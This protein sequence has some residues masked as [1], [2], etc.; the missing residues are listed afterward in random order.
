M[1][2]DIIIPVYNNR[3]YLVDALSSCIVQKYKN[4][5]IY[6]IDDNSDEPIEDV[7]K[8]F[9]SMN[10]EYIRNSKN[11]GPSASR[12]IGIKKGSGDLVSFLDSDD[13]WTPDKLLLSISEFKKDSNIGMTC[14]NYRIW[15]ERSR[16]NKQ[17]YRHPIVVDFNSLRRVNYVASGSVTVKRKVLD[18]VG[19][20]NEEYRVAEDYDLWIRIS[21][22]YKIKYIHDVLYY[23][24]CVSDGKSLTKRSDLISHSDD[25]HKKIKAKYYGNSS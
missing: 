15:N 24:S 16:L 7:I 1:K 18:D 13:I 22:K 25:V 21:K 12:N 23:Y 10:I 2:V 19:L 20:F 14:G 9:G 8:S 3:K 6:I 11:L 17:F 4:F 5:K